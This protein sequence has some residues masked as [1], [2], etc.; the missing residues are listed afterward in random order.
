MIMRELAPKYNIPWQMFT[1]EEELPYVP[2]Q[3]GTM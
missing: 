2:T 1:L 3:E